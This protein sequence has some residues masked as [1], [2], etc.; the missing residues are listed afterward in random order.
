M[1]DDSMLKDD[2][3]EV[4]KSGISSTPS[5]LPYPLNWNI[6]GRKN[7]C[8]ELKNLKLP[9]VKNETSQIKYL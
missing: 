6:L 8:I 5:K 7:R 2:V 3:I 4:Y 1:I 9:I